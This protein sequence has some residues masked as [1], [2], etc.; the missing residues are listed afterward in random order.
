MYTDKQFRL[1]EP[2]H[3]NILTSLAFN[4]ANSP[5]I[6]KTA[7][8][9]HDTTVRR[10]E[11]DIGIILKGLPSNQASPD[12]TQHMGKPD[13]DGELNEDEEW[14]CRQSDLLAFILTV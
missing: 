14:A 10:P 5:S 3:H 2:L 12:G 11:T 6:P 1:D 8:Q 13:E 9:F 7:A 4:L